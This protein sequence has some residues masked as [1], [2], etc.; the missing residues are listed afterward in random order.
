MD[1]VRIEL[2]FYANGSI[3]TSWYK[4]PGAVRY[5]AYM[6]QS[7][8]SGYLYNNQNLTIN[9]FVSPDRLPTNKDFRMYVDAY[10]SAG[11]KIAA[12][13]SFMNITSYTYDPKK[14]PNNVPEL[15]GLAA[16]SIKSK[17]AT[18]T[19]ATITWY[20]Q[21]N[22]TGYRLNFDNRSYD[23]TATTKTFTGLSSNR[24]YTFMLLTKTVDGDG[25]YGAVQKVT[26]PP[27]APSGISAVSTS[28]TVTVSWNKVTGA[29][30]YTV[31]FNSRDYT[32]SGSSTSL[33]ISGLQPKTTYNYKVRCVG[34]DGTGNYSSVRSVTTQAQTFQPP[35][36]ITKRSTNNSATISWSPVSGATGYDLK[37]NGSIYSETGTSR[38]FTGLSANT[39][40]RFQVRAKKTGVTGTYSAEQTVTTAP[41]T[42]SVSSAQ[43]THNTATVKWDAVPGA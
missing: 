4:V 6:T 32:A 21:P 7:G 9:C 29:N 14:V 39:A 24:S 5:H 23:L 41:R 19:S 31:S 12:G 35:A 26:T 38:T 33:K 43:A 15:K 16:P 18:E 2:S 8:K 20:A 42:P 1:K 10:N 40:Y 13:N 11:T 3:K 22:A 34:V 27:S 30:S 37:F 17:T 25:A 28:D 36:G